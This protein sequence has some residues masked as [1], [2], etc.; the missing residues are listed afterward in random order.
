MLPIL[1][2][3]PFSLCEDV[4]SVRTDLGREVSDRYPVGP[5]EL[6]GTVYCLVSPYLTVLIREDSPPNRNKDS[7][8]GQAC[9]L[10]SIGC[11]E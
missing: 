9:C 3:E 6:T 2:R 5:D 7:V 4:R 11:Q 1:G 8:L 10:R